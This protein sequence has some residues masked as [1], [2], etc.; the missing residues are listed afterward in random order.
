MK[1]ASKTI[2]VTPIRACMQAGYVQRTHEFTSV[3][4]DMKATVFVMEI[5]GKTVV[6]IGTD[7]IGTSVELNNRIQKNC[8][9]RGVVIDHY[10]FGASHNHSAAN[11][12]TNGNKMFGEADPEYIDL[13]EERFADTIV[14]LAGKTED[15][16]SVKY[17]N[18]DIDGLYS[19]R[20]DAN[21]LAD[22]KVHLLGFYKEDTMVALYVTLSMHNTVLGPLNYAITGETFGYLR[23]KLEKEY[24]CTVLMAQGTA[25]DM[26]NRQYRTGQ[27]FKDM[28]KLGENLFEQIMRKQWGWED[29]DMDAISH[30]HIVY[31]CDFY[32][33]AQAYQAKIADFEERLT[34]TDDLTERKVLLS[35]IKGFERKLEMGNGNKHIE[36]PAE[37]Y[38][39]NDVQIVCIPGELGSY[40][41]LLI[42]R[43][44]SRKVPL[45]WGYTGA[46]DL[47]YIVDKDAY[48]MMC[49]E[50]N[51]TVYP[52]GEPEQYAGYIVSQ[53]D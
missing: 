31:N 48:H 10:I 12:N 49:Q 51:T 5:Q 8:A 11:I 34:H 15:I 53:L 39:M 4:D 32:L 26:G 25:G 52:E 35:G 38:T 2:V 3:H 24:N 29:I 16:T 21:K 28:E 18:V 47:G 13:L 41:G 37:I 30:K 42:K 46:C 50:T 43:G 40:L 14:E 23:N 9:A 22:K 7:F 20:N 45:V 44:S 27:E 6:W 17:Q 33:D 19:N 1:L 36:M